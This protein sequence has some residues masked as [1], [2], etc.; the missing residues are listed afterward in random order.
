MINFG[1]QEYLVAMIVGAI[2]GLIHGLRRKYDHVKIMIMFGKLACWCGF[3]GTIVPNVIY[4]LTMFSTKANRNHDTDPGVFVILTIIVGVFLLIFATPFALATW[5]S[6][7][8]LRL[9]RRKSDVVSPEKN[10]EI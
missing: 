7:S 1:I 10:T 4:A 5:L 9:R 2:V 8:H 3:T 6:I